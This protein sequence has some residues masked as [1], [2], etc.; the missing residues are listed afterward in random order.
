MSPQSFWKSISETFIRSF[1]QHLRRPEK[2]LLARL[3]LNIIIISLLKFSKMADFNHRC[4]LICLMVEEIP[5]PPSS[6]K[7]PR[8]LP[9]RRRYTICNNRSGFMSSWASNNNL[10]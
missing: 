5:S 3:S 9:M 7:V 6:T 4:R 8:D 2:E 10:S 1:L